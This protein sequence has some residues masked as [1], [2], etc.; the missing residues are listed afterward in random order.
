METNCPA[1][2]EEFAKQLLDYG[3]P[4]QG[5]GAG[6]AEGA[7]LAPLLRPDDEHSCGPPRGAAPGG[8]HAGPPKR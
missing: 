2:A 6:A 4:Q 1:E 5:E 3:G 7:A 8:L